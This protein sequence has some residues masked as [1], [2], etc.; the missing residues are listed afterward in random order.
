MF[1]KNLKRIYSSINKIPMSCLDTIT[2]DKKKIGMSS[3][4][5]EKKNADYKSRQE[6]MKWS[7]PKQ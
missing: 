6:N 2:S 1:K 7:Y 5:T 3:P 4:F